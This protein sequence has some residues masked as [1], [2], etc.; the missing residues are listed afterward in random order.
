VGQLPVLK[1]LKDTI[2]ETR[3]LATEFLIDKI[4]EFAHPI[5]QATSPIF[6]RVSGR[7]LCR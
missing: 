2:G 1:A 6:D 4:F 3:I 7:T 5:G